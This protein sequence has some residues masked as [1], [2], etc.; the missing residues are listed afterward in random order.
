MAEKLRWGFL[1]TG[2]ITKNAASGV[3]LSETGELVAVGSRTREAADRFGE[4]CGVAR[5][6]VGYQGLVE[7]P[8][9]DA[10]YIALPNHMHAE[11]S[12]KCAEAGKHILCEKPLACNRKEAETIVEAARQNDVFLMEA[13]M[14]RTYPHIAKLVELLRQ[15][16]VGEIR[17]I[18]STFCFNAGDMTGNIRT[19]RDMAGG[20]IMDVGCYTVSAARLVAGAA[21]GKPFAE[22]L[23]LKGCAHIPAD[24]GVDMYAAA[25]ARFDGNIVA[26]LACGM[27]V[28]T[29]S[30]IHVYGSDG[31][32]HLQNPWLPNTPHLRLTVQRGGDIQTVAIDNS[33]DVYA[34]EVDTVAEHLEKRQA[35]PPCMSWEDSLGNMGTLDRW[36]ESIGLVFPQDA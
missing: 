20:G 24:V 18:Q 30:G 13:F 22:P 1:G 31:A 11:W 4:A 25:A 10:V 8:E 3:R 15:G 2:G 5:R 21:K 29:E 7:D 23:E 33:L 34:V 14:Y 16:A 26:H 12:I 27:Q 35:D 6:H 36:R 9:V 17:L 32:I 28:S 19:K